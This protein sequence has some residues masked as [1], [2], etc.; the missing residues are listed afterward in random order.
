MKEVVLNIKAKK[1]NSALNEGA[2]KLGD[3][4]S[5]VKGTVIDGAFH[6]VSQKDSPGPIDIRIREDKMSATIHLVTPTTDSDKSVTIEAIDHRLSELGVIFGIDREMI[7]KVLNEAVESGSTKNNI[8]IAKGTPPEAGQAAK[9]DLKIG[10]DAANSDPRACSIV[11]PGQVIAVKV[12]A[13]TGLPGQN[14]L[15][16]EVPPKAG[17]D[18]EILAGD[19]VLVDKAGI[20]FT[21]TVYGVARKTWKDISVTNL[22]RVSPDGMWVDMPIFPYLADNNPLTLEDIQVIV[23]N[24]GVKYGIKDDL[25]KTVLEAGEPVET[26]RV[27]ESTLAQDGLDAK[28]EFRFRLNNDDPEQIEN[29]RQ[30]GSLEPILITK[31]LVSAGDILAVKIPMKPPVDGRTITG[32]IL[33]GAKPNDIRLGTGENVTVLDDGLTYVVSEGVIAGYAEYA[34]GRV[35]VE[36]PLYISEDGLL[37]YLSIHPPS[38]NGLSLTLEQVKRMIAKAGIVHGLDMDAAPRAIEEATARKV[39][40]HE[41][42]IAKG[43][44]PENGSD[45][46]IDLKFQSDRLAGTIIKGSDRMD[47]RERRSIQNVKKGDILS[48]KTLPTKGRNGVD[49]FGKVIPAEPG[50]DFKLI[51]AG[52]VTLSADGLTMTSEIDGMV[53]L[54]DKNKIGVFQLHE[55]QGDVDLKTGNLSMDGSLNI[56]GWIRSGFMVRASGEI[57]V[58]GGIEDASVQSGAGI[59]ISG[60]ILGSDKGKIDT[61]GDLSAFFI[62][63]AQ[64]NVKGDIFVRDDIRNSRI[65]AGGFIEAMERKGRIIGGTIEATHSLTANEIGTAVG[66]KTLVYVGYDPNLKRLIANTSERI[67][68]YNRQKAKM[69]TILAQYTPKIK[70][71]SLPKE[72]LFRLSNLIKLRRKAVLIDAKLK[73]YKE[74]LFEKLNETENSSIEV[75]VNRVVYAGTVITIKDFSH[76]IKEDIMGKVKFVLNQD[77]NGVELVMC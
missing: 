73:K 65:S 75:T 35:F 34:N 76:E 31:E 13:S 28:I 19:N 50:K 29:E 51:P 60:G 9:L 27:V 53:I 39:P 23:K 15:G 74:Q 5:A 56:K 49:V 3:Q 59:H 21:S 47:Y 68:T 2:R 77:G 55:I 18:I 17:T 38:E 62:E 12:P 10:R 20:H 48:I 37:A 40:L 46:L 33:K 70:S 7:Q 69:D 1:E 63:N 44:A 64:V 72:T 4:S 42:I 57:H 11:K 43:D 52:N 22:V 58:G 24:A 16:E 54:K 30:K 26:F 8:T 41:V 6:N 67:E 36:N 25:I 32:A 71:K 66:V 61:S 14:V 45:A